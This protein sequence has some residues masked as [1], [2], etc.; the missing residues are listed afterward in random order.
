MDS[1]SDLFP[2]FCFVHPSLKYSTS[3]TLSIMPLTTSLANTQRTLS[4][5]QVANLRG[6]TAIVDVCELGTVALQ[7]VHCQ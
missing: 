5:G 1:E 6:M 4:Q 2:F 7:C 3:I